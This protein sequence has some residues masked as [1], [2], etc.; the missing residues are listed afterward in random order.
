MRSQNI[1]KCTS[2]IP[3]AWVPQ[4]LLLRGGKRRE[5]PRSPVI[6]HL[7]LKKLSRSN[8]HQQIDLTKRKDADVARLEI[9]NSGMLSRSC[10]GNIYI[11]LAFRLNDTLKR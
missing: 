5:E 6:H 9:Q 2:C 1:A 4:A 3:F 7:K 8:Y 10:Y 11:L